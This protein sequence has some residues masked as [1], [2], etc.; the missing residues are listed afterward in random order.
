MSLV[1][2]RAP[3]GD[4]TIFYDRDSYVGQYIDGSINAKEFEEQARSHAKAA[5]SAAT[6]D[7]D[8]STAAAVTPL[9]ATPQPLSVLAAGTEGERAEH[10]PFTEEDRLLLDDVLA[11][12][13]SAATS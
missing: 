9:G 11:D 13:G 7:L 4:G 6:P 8:I 2:G 1:T 12:N 10:F 3:I 5:K